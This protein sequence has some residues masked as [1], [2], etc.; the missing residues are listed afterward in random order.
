[1]TLQGKFVVNGADFCPLQIY[2]VGT[3]MAYSG[4]DQYRNRAGC[5][6]VPNLGPIPDGRYHIVKRQ[7]GDG[8]V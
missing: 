2:G 8:K 1:M 3:F 5:I 6:G 4:K 7:A